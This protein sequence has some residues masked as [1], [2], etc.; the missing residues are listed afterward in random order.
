MLLGGNMPSVHALYKGSISEYYN[1]INE[2]NEEYNAN[3]YIL[4][5]SE[6]NTASIKDNYN[7]NYDLYIKGI[8]ETDIDE[9]KRECI[10]TIVCD[11]DLEVQLIVYHVPHWHEKQFLFIQRVTV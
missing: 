9:F 11:D 1:V 4:T 7:G 2:V 3:L 5:K 8:M 10:S 6:F